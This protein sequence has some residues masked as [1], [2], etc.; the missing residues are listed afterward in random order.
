VVDKGV[1]GTLAKA[2]EDHPVQIGIVVDHNEV[3]NCY[4]IFSQ[5]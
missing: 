1:A 2:L 5:K 4:G 3:I